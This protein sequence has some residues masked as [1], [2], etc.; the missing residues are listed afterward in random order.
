[1]AA[2]IQSSP[3]EQGVPLA[4]THVLRGALLFPEKGFPMRINGRT[5]RPSNLAERRLL[6]SFGTNPLR[7]PR[8][9]NPFTVARR[10]RRAA[11][12]T[13]PDH[14]FVRELAMKTRKPYGDVPNPSPDLDLPEPVLLRGRESMKKLLSSI[15]ELDRLVRAFEPGGTR[16]A[17]ISPRWARH[18]P[19]AWASTPR[20]SRRL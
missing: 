10:L 13:S 11:R 9:M 20:N 7:V 5:L 6:L 2:L 19:S 17:R 12:G 14:D 16:W 8:N 18:W 4:R 3:D 1:M 15:A